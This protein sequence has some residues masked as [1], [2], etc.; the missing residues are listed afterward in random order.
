MFVYWAAC[1]KAQNR[2]R[3]DLPKSEFNCWAADHC[4]ISNKQD[5]MGAYTSASWLW[6]NCECEGIVKIDIFAYI[7]PNKYPY[8]SPFV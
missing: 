8:F 1:G 4:V 2:D 5:A 7:L 3:L 6:I